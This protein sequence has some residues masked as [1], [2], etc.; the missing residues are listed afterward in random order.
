MT[1]AG[2]AARRS[3]ATTIAG[4]G[5]AA[6]CASLLS[7]PTPA[8]GQTYY[9]PITKAWTVHG[10]GYGHGHGMSQYGAQGAALDGVRYRDII[11]F[12]YPGTTWDQV[13][14]N[15]R[16][17]ISADTTS[18]LEVRSRE[19]LVVRDLVGK[20]KWTLP[21]KDTIDRWRLLPLANGRT[22]IQ[23]HNATGWQRWDVPDHR[24]TLKGNAQFEA[25]GPLTLLVP[26]GSDVV[27]RT[28]RGILRSAQPYPGATT[29][30]T[31]NVLTM[32]QYVQGVV[33]YEMPASWKQQAL[34]AQAV[35][36]RTYAAFERA[37]NP[38]R[39]W[40]I[41]D[42]TSC[43][44]YGGV[45]AEQESSNN[46]VK[47]TAGQILTYNGK[48]AFTQFS[49][50]SGG[51][52]A[53]GGQPY[54]PAKRD[55]YDDFADNAMHSWQVQVSATTLENRHPE[56]G[57]LID[58]KVTRRD[59]NGQWNG[60]VIQVVLEGTK[61]KA[62]MTGDD[63]RWAYGLRSTWFSI[64]PTPIIE[65]WRHL[66]GKKSG[67]GVPESGEYA[68]DG[69]AAQD[70]SHGQILWS[71]DTGAKDLKGPIL[72]AYRAYG[73]ASSLLGWPAT[74]MMPAPKDGHK[75]R[76]QHGKM[77]ST[78]KTGAHVLYG[79]IMHRWER[80]GAAFSWLGFPT[81]NVQ[82]TANGLRC[83]FEGGRIL[84]DKATG[85]F[86]VVRF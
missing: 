2:V 5:A 75:V 61:G 20:A 13:K 38:K 80:E 16:V 60:R 46:A 76:F 67:L 10:H 49:S 36:A 86:T 8:A 41:C 50:S 30:D 85:E 19:G 24:D 35:A 28:Y 70:F 71:A 1:L 55:P 15:I 4:A 56:V 63:F 17:L 18:D 58:V 62:Y 59:G 72:K 69:G 79:R 74:G 32:D 22:A 31:V 43:Q 26:D 37:L 3:A 73:G 51:W 14:G 81:T 40:Q 47:A 7:G 52:T 66:G 53:D 82:Q 48:A 84:W 42:T 21:A 45:D 78:V 77:F 9:V 44:V 29:R 27:G 39:Y 23:L 68:Y 11:D 64:A 33:P 83:T 12:Y 6:L 34:R 57:R 54:L 65:R 25:A